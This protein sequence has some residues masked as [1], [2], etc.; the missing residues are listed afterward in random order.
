LLV[1]P[2]RWPPT[3]DAE[4]LANQ[5]DRLGKDLYLPQRFYAV[6]GGGGPVCQGDVVQLSADMP[7]LDEEGNAV[8][9]QSYDLW[10]VA[11]NTCD[12]ER[13]LE[14]V[15]WSQIVPVSPVSDAV[16][17]GREFQAARDYSSYRSFYLPPWPNRQGVHGVADLTLIATVDKRCLT[18]KAKV[19][20]RL[21]HEAWVLLHS[22]LIRFMARGDGRFDEGP[23][24]P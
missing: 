18:G 8:T 1:T 20:A 4:Q 9:I 19:E 21:G 11:G 14:S 12:F 6:D 3:Y 16:I 22:C 23:A 17:G 2:E 10:L 13:S 5:I 24:A 15:R 7:V